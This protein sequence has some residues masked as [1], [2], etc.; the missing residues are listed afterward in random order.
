MKIKNYLRPTTGILQK[1][2]LRHNSHCSQ[3]EQ[4]NKKLICL[5]L[6]KGNIIEWILPV[7]PSA[8]KVQ[9]AAWILL[10]FFRKWIPS[11]GHILPFWSFNSWQEVGG[12]LNT[13]D[14]CSSS[15]FVGERDNF[16]CEIWL[17]SF[18]F[19]ASRSPKF[20]VHLSCSHKNYKLNFCACYI[21]YIVF[22]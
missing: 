9:K 18:S 17:F 22:Q 1:K 20:L 13:V 2:T 21:C 10:F 8:G 12:L 19:S 14:E 16:G 5:L 4:F 3:R 11:I 15:R 6:K 7:E